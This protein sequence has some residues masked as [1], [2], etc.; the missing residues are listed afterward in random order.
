MALRL[1]Y[2]LLHFTTSF[3][4]VKCPKIIKEKM[5]S[6]TM[7][8]KGQ[9]PVAYFLENSRPHT[10]CIPSLETFM[11]TGAVFSCTNIILNP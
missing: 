2:L 6:K 7:P 9:N 11:Q 10:F 8:R 3:V 5:V 1:N 4:Y